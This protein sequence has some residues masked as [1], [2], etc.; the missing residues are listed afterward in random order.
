MGQAAEAHGE[1]R[2]AAALRMRP[3]G[4]GGPVNAALSATLRTLLEV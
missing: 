3:K 2:G 4:M 1:P